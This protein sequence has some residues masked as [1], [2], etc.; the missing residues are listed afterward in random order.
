MWCITLVPHALLCDW[1]GGTLATSAVAEWFSRECLPKFVNELARLLCEPFG[2]SV[3]H[4]KG[5]VA[6]T[7]VSLVCETCHW[8]L[9]HSVKALKSVVMFMQFHWRCACECIL[10]AHMRKGSVRL[11][12]HKSF[13]RSFSKYV[14]MSLSTWNCAMLTGLAIFLIFK[15]KNP[16]NQIYLI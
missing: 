8:L 9:F 11:S 5:K 13:D 10:F 4:V 2:T 16:K 7:L 14:L 15:K 3:R 6:S 12:L 1:S